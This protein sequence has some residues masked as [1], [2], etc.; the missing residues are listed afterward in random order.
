LYFSEY[1]SNH[2]IISYVFEALV[3]C[4]GDDPVGMDSRSSEQEIINIARHF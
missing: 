1:R 4:G 3:Q 2:N